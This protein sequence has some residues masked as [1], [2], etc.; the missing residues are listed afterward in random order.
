MDV[1]YE[2]RPPRR[3]ACV[4]DNTGK[5]FVVLR[6]D[7]DTGDTYIVTAVDA[8]AF[9]RDAKRLTSAERGLTRQM[10]ARALEMHTV[11][12]AALERITGRLTG[13]GQP[14][15]RR[16]RSERSREHE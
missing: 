5:S 11:T 9:L 14:R 7:R 8:C 13:L 10:R 4:R 15:S 16:S 1:R 2:E 3:G 12:S 6:V